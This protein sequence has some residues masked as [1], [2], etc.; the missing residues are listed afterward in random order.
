MSDMRGVN[1][2]WEQL[3]DSEIESGKHRSRIGGLWDE[4]GSLQFAYI[5]DQGLLPAHTLL[6]I[7][8]GPL[9]GG[10]HFIRHL[11]RGRYIG[12]DI[13]ESFLK[14]ARMEV[15]RAGLS[16]KQPR[17]LH[18]ENFQFRD[19][20]GPV[21]F[22]VAI[23]LFTHLHINLI[24]RCLI[25]LRPLLGPKGMLCATFFVA[26]EDDWLPDIEHMQGRV[27]HFDSD[28]CHYPTGMMAWMAE[29]C[30]YQFQYVGDWGHPRKQ[31]MGIFTPR[32]P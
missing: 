17:L 12:V 26:P 9:R 8:C 23:S 14:A 2:Y 28:P 19:V 20:A 7:G 5:K 31:M 32:L 10:L 13:N 16:D 21:D 18:D 25:S 4:I 1:N 30:G 22:A 15:E 11:D 3:T 29:R 24:M 27:S 6:D